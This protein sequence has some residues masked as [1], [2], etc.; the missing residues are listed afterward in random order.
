MKKTIMQRNFFV[1]NL[2]LVFGFVFFSNSPKALAIECASNPIILN[3]NEDHLFDKAIV[4]QQT[5]M[6]AWVNKL[7]EEIILL[8]YVYDG[9]SNKWAEEN[10]ED[11]SNI[12]DWIIWQTVYPETKDYLVAA[13]WIYRNAKEEVKTIICRNVIRVFEREIKN[14]GVLRITYPKSYRNLVIKGSKSYVG[15]FSSFGWSGDFLN[16][17][18]YYS[19]N[20]WLWKVKEDPYFSGGRNTYKG[21]GKWEKSNYHFQPDR[22]F[23][24]YPKLLLNQFT[25]DFKAPEFAPGEGNGVS[26]DYDFSNTVVYTRDIQQNS[27]EKL[28]P[29]P[30]N[31]F[32]KEI[33]NTFG[34]LDDSHNP[35]LVK[36]SILDTSKAIGDSVIFYDQY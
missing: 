5:N 30:S 14:Y 18:V 28:P 3:G 21:P 32:S 23:L 24:E 4:D 16:Y 10:N 31:Q 1:F 6:T 20:N 27:L 36:D 12:H 35:G 11:N 15:Y 26:A 13:A 19:P 2:F 7:P 33:N 8:R 9:T 34:Y 17:R 22:T 25:I 29:L